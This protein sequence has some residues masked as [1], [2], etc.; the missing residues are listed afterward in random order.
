MT[1]L[2][3]ANHLKLVTVAEMQALEKAADA[4][5]HRYATM[6]EI[7]GRAVADLI[8]AQTGA[9]RPVLV[10]AGPGNNG[11]D[12]LVCARYLH[13]AG[14]PVRAY[15]W[16][17]RTTPADDY[18]GHYQK[19]IH[20]GIP[21]AHTDDDP[22][23]V[24]L[25]RWLAEGAPYIIVDALLGTGNN[26]PITG[27]L[28]VLLD[29]VRNAIA[30]TGSSVVAVDCPS[31]LYA[32]SGEIDPH[33][34]AADETVTFAYAKHGHY[35]FPGADASGRLH[36]ADIGIDPAL[37]EDL[38]TF[39]LDEATVR[40]WLPKRSNNSHKGSFGKVM[41]AVGSHNF[42][43]AAF[44]ACSAAGRV[45]AGLVTGAVVE[46]VWSV[47]A[48]KLPEPTWVPL[49]TGVDDERGVIA[50]AAAPILLAALAGYSALVLGCGLNKKPTTVRFVHRLLE[51]AAQLPPTLIDADGLNC[52]AQLADWPQLLPEAVILTPHAAELGRLCGLSVQEVLPQRWALA[53]QK[54][55]E[56]QAI[57]LAKG[58]YTVI[59]HPDG[60]LA[61]LPIATP[62]L[63]TAGTGDVLSGTIAGLLAQGL[64]PFAAACAGAWLHG[65][66]G[67]RCAAA[68]GTAGVVA[69]DL[70]PTLPQILR[71]INARTLPAS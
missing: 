54:A 37:A 56:W 32:D 60:R 42:P 19:V 11:G 23:F 6:M 39:L 38:Q 59:A 44:L 69:S 65:Q 66:A 58:P 64:D 51:G 61:V 26:R 35:Q 52:L 67:L 63:A 41:A 46:A 24:T 14:V 27:Q 49:P 43:G 18:E 48:G 45:G 10:L 25:Q 31:G 7:A 5:G 29:L 4:A 20:L 68:L 13:E 70:L 40:A 16:K 53:R 36:V 17:R 55:A 15:L 62:A 50:E 12:G 21:T 2:N 9:R 3:S 47:V 71:A 33:T 30:D 1:T 22:D 8:L 34:L 57:V 28:A